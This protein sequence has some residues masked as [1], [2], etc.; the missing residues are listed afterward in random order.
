[1]SGLDKTTISASQRAAYG[2]ALPQSSV[3]LDRARGAS[4][5][6]AQAVQA[7]ARAISNS[8]LQAVCRADAGVAMQPRVMIAVLSFCYAFDIFASTDVE[9]VMR[10]DMEF[11]RLCA[12]EFPDAQTLRR[13]RRYNRDALEH[14]LVE[15]LRSVAA[16]DGTRPSDAALRDDAHD[17]VN[18]A[19]LM[20]VQ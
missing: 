17:R 15:V 4:A 2:L 20:D 10:R 16:E 14:C 8:K 13:F 1:M 6:P 9:D 11:R 3:V 18:T 12:N 19:I 5:S 7:A